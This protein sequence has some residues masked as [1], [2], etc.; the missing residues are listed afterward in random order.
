VRRIL[1]GGT[2]S[3]SSCCCCGHCHRRPETYVRSK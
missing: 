2:F 3:W 1:I